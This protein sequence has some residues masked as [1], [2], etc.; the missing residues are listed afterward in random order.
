MKNRAIWQKGMAILLAAAMACGLAGCK[1]SAL[2]DVLGK[3]ENETGKAATWSSTICEDAEY[4]YLCGRNRIT[5]VKKGTQETQILW[6]QEAPGEPGQYLYNQ[7]AGL[8][9]GNQIYFLA[10]QGES[11]VY[12]PEALCVIST[13]GSGFER[14]TDPLS[15]SGM[16]LKDGVIYLD[17]SDGVRAYSLESKEASA[18]SVTQDA[19]TIYDVIGCPEGTYAE[20]DKYWLTREFTD[21]SIL[22]LTDKKTLEKKELIRPDAG[23]DRIVVN[24]PALRI[25]TFV[26][27][28]DNEYVYLEQEDQV[29]GTF[30]YQKL[31]LATGEM[32]LVCEYQNEWMRDYGNMLSLDVR[33]GVRDGYLYYIG[34]REYKL[35]VMRRS[36]ASPE[37]EELLGDAFYDTGIGAVGT[38][39]SRSEEVY[40]SKNPEI[41]IFYAG[42][43]RI[44]V[45]ERFAGAAKINQYLEKWLDD[46]YAEAKSSALEQR[47]Q[48]AE[49]VEMP[50]VYGSGPSVTEAIYCDGKYL[51][52][53]QEDSDYR[54]GPH[55]MDYWRGF[56]FDLQTGRRM[57]LRDVIGNS[58]EELKQ[59]VVAYFGKLI[60]EDP[61]GFREDAKEYIRDSINLNYDFY[62]RKDGIHFDFEPYELA[63]YAAGFQE[64]VIPYTEFRI[65]IPIDA[66]IAQGVQPQP[67]NEPQIKLASEDWGLVYGKDGAPSRGNAKAEDLAYYNAYYRNANTTEKVMYFTSDCGYENGNTAAILDAL[68]KHNVKATFFVVG[69]FLKTAPDLVKRMVEEGH[70]VGNHTFNHK[71]MAAIA[72]I[73]D[74]QKELDDVATLFKEVTGKE[75]SPYYRPPQGKC[76]VDNLRMAKELGYYTMFWSIAHVDWDV[77]KQPDYKKSLDLLVSRAHPGAIILLHNTSKTNADILDELLTEW[78]KLG[79][80]F[81]PLSDLTGE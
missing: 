65:K 64:A 42:V 73:E 46:V 66:A 13:D 61:K 22:Y 3:K 69:H 11:G 17:A 62:L 19:K 81:R 2:P 68:K 10:N 31:S 49:V 53:R 5:K 35:Y 1:N 26:C 32:S 29:D 14:L 18:A 52:F 48:E 41:E 37:K 25:N 47:A 36:L 44:V 80:T 50:W 9:V 54:G 6:E 24:S 45:D 71:N 57:S 70:A 4:L 67:D 15:T 28:M 78:E 38:L 33:S 51:S 58:E 23:Q 76:N 12:A 39:T 27:G 8:L 74:F 75:I 16:V 40:S 79:Y 59:T 21:E 72:Q 7:S 20:N 56:T 63:S 30:R 55:G 60:D 43:S 77:N 34:E